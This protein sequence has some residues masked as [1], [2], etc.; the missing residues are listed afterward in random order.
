MTLT[1]CCF[2][3]CLSKMCFIPICLRL[4]HFASQY[5]SVHHYHSIF[6]FL[7]VSVFPLSLS[8]FPSMFVHIC[9][10]VCVC[11]CTDGCASV[12]VPASPFLSLSLFLSFYFCPSVDFYLGA[13]LSISLLDSPFPVILSVSLSLSV[14]VFSSIVLSLYFCL[15][16][17]RHYFTDVIIACHTCVRY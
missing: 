14:N 17:K 3:R 2:Q 8:F 5:F 1:H 12:C 6:A 9:L 10:F 4:S 13:V 7:F 11:M 15:I 16:C